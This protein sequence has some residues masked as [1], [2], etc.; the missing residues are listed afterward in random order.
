[1]HELIPNAIQLEKSLKDFADVIEASE[2]LLFEKTTFLVVSHCLK[3]DHDDLQRFEKISNIIKQFK[4]SCRLEKINYYY[5][6]LTLIKSFI[7]S[8]FDTSFQSIEIKNSNYTIIIDLFT[9]NTYIM[10]I[11]SDPRISKKKK[12]LLN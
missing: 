11:I 5:F 7:L 3:K 9:P 2:I 12:K 8:K 4:L 10:V 6:Y 1:V